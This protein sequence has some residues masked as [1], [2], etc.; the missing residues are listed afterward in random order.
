VVLAVI[1][2]LVVV[3]LVVIAVRWW[4]KLLVV[5]RLLNPS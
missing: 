2:V 1:A 3:V 5:V 4:G